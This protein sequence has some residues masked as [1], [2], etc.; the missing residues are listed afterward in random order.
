[1]E[2]LPL[3]CAIIAVTRKHLNLEVVWT[4]EMTLLTTLKLANFKDLFLY[5]DQRYTKNFPDSVAH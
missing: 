1:M 5:I 2:P 4:E 3:S